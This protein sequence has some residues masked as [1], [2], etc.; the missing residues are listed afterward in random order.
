MPERL[1]SIVARLREY[2]ADRRRSPRFRVRLACAVSLY[3]PDDAR[4]ATAQVVT[5]YTRDLSASG[6]AIVLPA[7][8]IGERYLTAAGT[9]LR[10]QLAHPAGPLELLA[11]P[12]H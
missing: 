5:G 10:I 8:R 1:R 3:E 9:T 6:L 11:T 7:V 4:R 2:V 12:V